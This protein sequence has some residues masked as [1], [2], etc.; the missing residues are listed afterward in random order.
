MKHVVQVN[1][2]GGHP[3][4][5]AAGLENVRIMEE[6]NLPGRAAE[7]GAHLLEGLKSLKSQYPM[8][9]DVRGKGLLIGV[10]LIKNQEKAPLPG[11]DVAGIMA[12]VMA[13]GVIISRSAHTDRSLGNTLTFCPPL[14][15]TTQEADTVVAT[16]DKVLGEIA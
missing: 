3:V 12:R 13:N 5:C 1:T 6:E 14:V 2:Y 7:V 4:A 16:I 9:G 11:T 10:E 8:I 15:L